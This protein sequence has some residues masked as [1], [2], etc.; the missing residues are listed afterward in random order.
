MLLIDVILFVNFRYSITD[1]KNLNRF[2]V[3]AN[4][5]IC[6]GKNDC[7]IDTP[8]FTN[9]L[10]PKPLCSFDGSF[11]LEGKCLYILIIPPN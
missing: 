4:M 5:R 11:A 8:L 6:L 7:P 1:L 10:F 3:S 2:E 9:V